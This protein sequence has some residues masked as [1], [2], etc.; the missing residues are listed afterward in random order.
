M[1]CFLKQDKGYNQKY[2]ER[3]NIFI[4]LFLNSLNNKKQITNA[5]AKA[6]T[7]AMVET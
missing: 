2:D 4:D 5:T 7:I 1:A 3:I 6:T